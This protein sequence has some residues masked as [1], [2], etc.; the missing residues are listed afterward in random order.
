[1]AIVAAAALMA[2]NFL[3]L[4][5]FKAGSTLVISA[6]TMLFLLGY[7]VALW[8]SLPPPRFRYRLR[9]LFIVMTLVA[10]ACALVSWLR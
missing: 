3:P 6:G 2:I 7:L 4:S 9:T 5:D 10:V 8:R 1:V